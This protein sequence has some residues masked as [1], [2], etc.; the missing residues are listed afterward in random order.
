MDT[1]CGNSSWIGEHA[2]GLMVDMM[3]NGGGRWDNYR[4]KKRLAESLGD[5][6]YRCP[7]LK[8]LSLNFL[9]KPYYNPVVNTSVKNT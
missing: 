3:L 6:L 1:S 2:Q 4:L 9:S 7:S 8:T 5:I